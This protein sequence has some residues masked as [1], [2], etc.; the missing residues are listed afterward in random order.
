M[1]R[2]APILFR[3]MQ[4]SASG[5]GTG[6]PGT[7]QSAIRQALYTAIQQEFA[8]FYRWATSDLRLIV[9]SLPPAVVAVLPAALAWPPAH[10]TV[11]SSLLHPALHLVRHRQGGCLASKLS[12]ARHFVL[13][14]H[15]SAGAA[16]QPPAA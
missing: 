15:G 3:H 8:E 9:G 6:E 12:D 13:Q 5:L 7:S 16:G 11:L 4:H 2:H 1:I 10:I 14:A